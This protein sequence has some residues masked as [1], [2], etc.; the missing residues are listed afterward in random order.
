MNNLPAGDSTEELEKWVK[1]VADDLVSA[2]ESDQTYPIRVTKDADATPIFQDNNTRATGYKV[3]GAIVE[4]E[5]ET[6][7]ERWTI[8][9]ESR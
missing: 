8:I 6:P 2:S 7:T 1:A 5:F 4:M 3:D 9:R